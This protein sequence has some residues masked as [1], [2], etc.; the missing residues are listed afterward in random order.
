MKATLTIEMPARCG[1]CPLHRQDPAEDG[2][3][4]H[5]CAQGDIA[6]PRLVGWWDDN[7]R[8]PGDGLVGYVAR[9]ADCPLVPVE[10]E[11]AR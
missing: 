4:M 6:S 2:V 9:H 7:R 11:A 1:R 3:P 8:T 10:T 5:C